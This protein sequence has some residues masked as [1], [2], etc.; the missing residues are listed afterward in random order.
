MLNKIYENIK[1]FIKDNYKILIIFTFLIIIFNIE[2]DYEIYS[3]GGLINIEDRILVNS[4]Y[5]QEGSYNLT[6]VSGKKGIIPFVL[7]SFVIPGWDLVSLDE[8]RVENESF[9]DIVKRNQVYLKEGNSY[10]IIS[11]FNEANVK[12]EIEEKNI[13]VLYILENAKTEIKVGDEILSIE[14]KSVTSTDNFLE[15]LKNYKENDVIEIE[16]KRDNKKIITKSIVDVIAGENKIGLYLTT[17]Y[18]IDT[19]GKVEINYKNNESGSSGGLMNA[20]YIYDYLV[21]EDLTSSLKISGTGT[22]DENGNVGE[23][24]GVKYKILGAD[25]KSAD[26]FLVPYENYEEAKETKDKYDL[27]IKIIKVRTLKEAINKL[28]DIK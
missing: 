19:F 21:K 24:S 4:S 7:L 28:K 20:L 11:A 9:D 26:I 8:S 18:D 6:Y 2:L 27:D 16:V 12:Y 1:N 17:I 25:K 23:I 14:G 3:S 5:K 15:I 13:V 10:S 22:I